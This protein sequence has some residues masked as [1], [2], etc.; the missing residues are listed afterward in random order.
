MGKMYLHLVNASLCISLPALLPLRAARH[1][2]D[3]FF[4]VAFGV[5]GVAG[6]HGG[7]VV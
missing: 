1:V 7:L 5:L 6:D 4:G 3:C 2:A